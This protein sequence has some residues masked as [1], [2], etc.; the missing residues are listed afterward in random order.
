[1]K[2]ISQMIEKKMENSR[3]LSKSH[4]YELSYQEHISAYLLSLAYL[5]LND[6]NIKLKS[7]L[8]SKF[9]VELKPLYYQKLLNLKQE[10]DFIIMKAIKKIGLDVEEQSNKWGSLFSEFTWAILSYEHMEND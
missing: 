1:M 8:F 5:E 6:K 4:Q 9:I 10:E 3:I 7:H 2:L